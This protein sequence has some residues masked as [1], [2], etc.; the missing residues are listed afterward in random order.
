MGSATIN[1]WIEVTTICLIW[2]M[3]GFVIGRTK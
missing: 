2:F 3:F 1:E